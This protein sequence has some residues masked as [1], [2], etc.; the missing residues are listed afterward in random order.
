MAVYKLGAVAVPMAMQF[1][2]DAIAYRL[3]LSGAK[4]IVLDESGKA[5]LDAAGED[6]PSCNPSSASAARRR[7]S[8]STP[9]SRPRRR[10]SPRP[11]PART[12]RR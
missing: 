3:D 11:I 6:F 8:I 9:F 2:P 7:R 1:G 5:K 12:I 4:A 10:I